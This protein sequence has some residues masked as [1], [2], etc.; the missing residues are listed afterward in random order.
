MAQ[1]Q[2]HG[3]QS[4]GSGD[5]RDAIQGTPSGTEGA[6]TGQGVEKGQ[7]RQSAQDQRNRQSSGGAETYQRNDLFE[8]AGED[9]RMDQPERA[10]SQ[11]SAQREGMGGHQHSGERNNRQDSDVERGDEDLGNQHSDKDPNRER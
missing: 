4:I 1:N 8:D 7:S 9:A 5:A 2:Q 6:T 10:D 11:Q 3:E